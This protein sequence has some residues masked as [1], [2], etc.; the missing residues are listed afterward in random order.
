LVL[1]F[2]QT[3]NPVFPLYNDVFRSEKWAPVNERF[4]LPFFGIGTSASD[5]VSFWWRATEAPSLFGQP[6]PAWF[7]GLP[8]ILG[9]SVLL[10]LPALL[11]SRGALVWTLAAFG[12]VLVWFFF[13]QYHRYGLPAF[14]LLCLPAGFAVTEAARTLSRWAAPRAVVLTG[15]VGSWFAAGVVVAFAAFSLL[16]EHFP[17]GVLLGRESRSEYR[18]R[19]V[20]NYVAIRAFDMLTRGTE[21]EGAILG[22][23]YNYFAANRL[24]DVIVPG[25]LSPFRRIVE[26]GRPFPEMAQALVEARVRYFVYDSNNPFGYE[27]WPPRWLAE[28]VLDRRFIEGHMEVAFEENGVF[29]YRVVGSR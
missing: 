22:W 29:V 13:S 16:P 20:P 18:E 19:W 1:R 5:F 28:S 10:V 23:P 9:I 24:F 15:L 25:E 6:A 26:E 17:T 4:D 7:L 8:L 2:F 27:E 21:D 12:C 14:A 3:G 11:R